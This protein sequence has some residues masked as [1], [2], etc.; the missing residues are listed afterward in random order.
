MDPIGTQIRRTN[1]SSSIDK[2]GSTSDRTLDSSTGLWT[3]MSSGWSLEVASSG[4]GGSDPEDFL[5]WGD[6][7]EERSHSIF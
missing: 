4:D 7:G 2:C 1:E 5:S 3:T 6:D